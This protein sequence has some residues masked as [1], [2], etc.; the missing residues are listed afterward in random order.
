[1]DDQAYRGAQHN[2]AVR[3]YIMRSLAKGHNNSLLCRQLVNVM[4]NDGV[5]ISPDIS[6]HLDYLVGKGYIE[7]TNDRINSYNAYA[8]DAVI[9]LTVEGIDLLEGSTPDDPGVLI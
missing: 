2:K 9:R 8:N 4:V 7:F 6:K 5:I 3:G 1:M